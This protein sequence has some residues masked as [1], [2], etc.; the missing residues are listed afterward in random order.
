M[1]T[2]VYLI[3]HGIAAERGL[4]D[5]DADRPLTERGVEKTTQVAQRLR[6]LNLQ[7]A[8]TLASPLVRA[9]QTAEILQNV[10]ITP[11]IEVFDALAPDGDIRHW[12]AWLACWQPQNPARS[13]ALVGHQPDLTQW[14]QQLVGT[15]D[16]ARWQLKKAGVI[17]L[18]VPNAEDALGQSLLFLLVPPRFLL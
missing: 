10:G 6:R 18:Q 15:T 17:G 12:L 7:L 9:R 16:D 1:L 2:T 14:A 11:A 5:Q 4:Y 3:R 8:L 13:V